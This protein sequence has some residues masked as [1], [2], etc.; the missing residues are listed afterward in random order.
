MIGS[1]PTPPTTG[2]DHA[3]SEGFKGNDLFIASYEAQVLFYNVKGET[4]NWHDGKAHDKS[5]D[6]YRYG[7][8]LTPAAPVDRGALSGSATFIGWTTQRSNEEG[9]NGGYAA[10]TSPAL[11]DLKNN[12]AFYPAGSMITVVGPTDFYPVYSDYVSNIMTVFEGNEQDELE[13]V[14]QRVDV[15][16]T[17]V[18]V[19]A[20]KNGTS[21][22]TVQVRGVDNKP[23]SEGGTLPMATASGLVRKQAECRWVFGRGA[24]K[25]RSQL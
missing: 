19:Q 5:T 17:H 12:G 11:A 22:Y 18:D 8:G 14:T 15:G 23:L 10:I 3:E 25:P 1:R 2:K 9:M 6:W 13:D 4:L 7:V 20:G 24:R 21:S 16:N